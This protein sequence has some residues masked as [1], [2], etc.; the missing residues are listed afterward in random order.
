M[1]D[2]RRGLFVGVE[3]RAGVGLMPTETVCARCATRT[4]RGET[5]E[6]PEAYRRAEYSQRVQYDRWVCDGCRA[7][8]MAEPVAEAVAAHGGG[9]DVEALSRPASGWMTKKADHCR[10]R[11]RVFVRLRA[12]GWSYP[13]IGRAFN[14]NHSAVLY[15]VRRAKLAPGA[16]VAGG[17]P[18]GVE[19][20]E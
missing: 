17:E 18:S 9:F 3:T 20:R 15:A 6:L 7:V 19:S 1:A 14:L 16:G 13:A 12:M 2:D 8:I 10:A 5:F 4:S 11:E